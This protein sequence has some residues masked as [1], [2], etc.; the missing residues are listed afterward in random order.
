M[1]NLQRVQTAN[2]THWQPLAVRRRIRYVL[3]CLVTTKSWE[4]RGNALTCP[5]SRTRPLR[6]PDEKMVVSYR[7]YP[8]ACPFPLLTGRFSMLT[9][10]SDVNGYIR[11]HKKAQEPGCS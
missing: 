5:L 9:G 11:R 8:K 4:F 6:T 1:C 3:P 2:F 7:T 10:I